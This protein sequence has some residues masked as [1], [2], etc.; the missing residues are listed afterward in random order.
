MHPAGGRRLSI[1]ARRAARAFSGRLESGI[2]R[3]LPKSE[4]IHIDSL[5]GGLTMPSSYSADLRERVIGRVESGSSRREAAEQFEISASAA[6]KWLE[7]WH[8][9]GIATAKPRGGS[10]SPLEVHAQVLLVLIA[11]HP[12]LTLDEVVGGLHKRRIASSRSALWRF[13]KRHKI[14]LKKH[15]ARGRARTSGRRTGPPALDRRARTA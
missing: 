11:E 8:D 13:F 2:P 10:I 4:S 9:R 6:I 14:T 15:S 7:R 1:A 3:S 12:D 5:L